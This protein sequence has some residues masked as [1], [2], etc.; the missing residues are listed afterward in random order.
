M[1]NNS[2]VVTREI[3]G[4][5]DGSYI[6]HVVNKTGQKFKLRADLAR[7]T[8]PRKAPGVTLICHRISGARRT[9]LGLGGNR[10]RN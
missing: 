10:S 1:A 8:S 2:I 9:G 5:G 7:D 3:E 4:Y 6:P